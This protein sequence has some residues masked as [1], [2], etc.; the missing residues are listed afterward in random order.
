MKNVLPGSSFTITF[1]PRKDAGQLDN[2]TL[3]NKSLNKTVPLVKDTDI[4]YNDAEYYAEA[5]VTYT[6]VEGDQI[7][8]TIFDDQGTEM[9]VGEV[10]VTAKAS[11]NEGKYVEQTS[12]SEYIT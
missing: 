5:D 11:I 6:V 1:I 2:A 12:D 3:L 4:V 8:I 9:Y 7:R 10:F